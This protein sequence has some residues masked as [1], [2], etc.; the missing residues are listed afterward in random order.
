MIPN[1]SSYSMTFAPPILSFSLNESICV[2]RMEYAG[3]AI[4]I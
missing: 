4:E 3:E 2:L 1:G